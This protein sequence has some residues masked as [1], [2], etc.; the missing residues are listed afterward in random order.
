MLLF[1]R[2]A[3]HLA[4]HFLCPKLYFDKLFNS[5]EQDKT[6]LRNSS[7][8]NESF[9]INLSS[10]CSK[11]A[12]S[13]QQ[14]WIWTRSKKLQNIS[15]KVPY[16]QCEHCPLKKWGLNDLSV[17]K[18]WPKI[19]FLLK[20]FPWVAQMFLKWNRFWQQKYF[21]NV[22]CEMCLTC[23]WSLTDGGCS[24]RV[25]DFTAVSGLWH[26]CVSILDIR[27]ASM[28]LLFEDFIAGLF[29]SLIKRG[30]MSCWQSHTLRHWQNYGKLFPPWNKNIKNVIV[31]LWFFYIQYITQFW[32]KML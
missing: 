26:H 6:F 18:W 20:L 9:V 29:L 12:L 3:E 10:C 21:T 22:T 27:F 25:S 30:F 11:P 2:N 7:P 1:W 28:Q 16:K 17:N 14:N 32:R 5:I 13:M 23:G 15:I 19:H 8:K 24:C 31:T 4:S